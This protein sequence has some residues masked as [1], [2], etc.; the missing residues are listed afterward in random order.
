MLKFRQ[1]KGNNSAITEDITIKLH[2]HN[3]TMAIY[4]FSIFYPIGYLVMAEEGKSRKEKFWKFKV[5][6]KGPF[7]S[8]DR[9]TDNAKPISI[10]LQ[11]RITSSEMIL[12]K[13]NIEVRQARFSMLLMA[14]FS[15]LYSFSF[16]PTC[17]VSL[18][19]HLLSD[20]HISFRICQAMNGIVGKLMMMAH[21]IVVDCW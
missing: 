20:L 15:S 16:S 1:S 11:R 14:S 12:L 2:V 17:T 19:T 10:R 18:E 7:L 13:R 8:T 21:Q 4:V 9:Q 6:I 3:L 5:P